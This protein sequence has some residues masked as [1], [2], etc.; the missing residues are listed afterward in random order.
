M[1]LSET[2]AATHSF[3]RATPNSV[4]CEKCLAAYL[5]VDRYEVLKSIRELIHAPEEGPATVVSSGG[6]EILR[7]DEIEGAGASR[8]S[9]PLT[10]IASFFAM[11]GT[12]Q[13]LAP[14]I[15][16]GSRTGTARP[17][18]SKSPSSH[19]PRRSTTF[20]DLTSE[21]RLV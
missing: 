5:D 8:S 13:N 10:E 15:G 18:F 16:R 12:T 7:I 3:L 14:S 17:R 19:R 6:A 20:L 21:T 2:A 1:T 9:A 11:N 4:A